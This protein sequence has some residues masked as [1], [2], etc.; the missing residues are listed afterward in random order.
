MNTLLVTV[1]A[2]RAD[3]VGC[4]G[5]SRDTTPALDAFAASNT[6]F[7]NAFANGTFTSAALPAILTGSLRKESTDPL[8]IDKNLLVREP[9]LASV[10]RD[11]GV[12]TRGINTNLLFSVWYERIE[13]FDDFKQFLPAESDGGGEA[14]D[15][16]E[17]DGDRPI[18]KRVGTPV[19]EALG[20][21]RRARQ[22]YDRFQ[23]AEQL[24]STTYYDAAA[25]TD[26]VLKWIDDHDEKSFFIWAHYMDPHEPYGYFDSVR[27][28]PFLNRPIEEFDPSH[29]EEIAKRARQDPDS[30]SERE[31]Q[32][33]I[34][35]YDGYIRF[36]DEHVGRLFDE[37]RQRGVYEETQVIVTADH[38]EE[39][40]EHGMYY[41]HNKPYDE[42]I[43]VPLLVKSPVVESGIRSDQVRH[44]DIAPTVAASHG[45]NT[46]VFDG[47]SLGTDTGDRLVVALGT[48][49]PYVDIS[50]R[51]F[52]ALR[53]PAWKV[54]H[55]DDEPIE[56]YNLEKDSGERTN[57]ASEYPERTA[58]LHEELVGYLEWSGDD[59]EASRSAAL[60]D[61]GE[62]V[63]EHLSDLGY[64]E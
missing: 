45:L 21:K 54:I 29:V 19:A 2:L 33:L 13:G 30:I 26:Q 48:D 18:I 4:H 1:D 8:E 42:L 44:I 23:S 25:V 51:P 53:Y 37:L 50:S 20:V 17:D 31:R 28:S 56:L 9:N 40:G 7:A 6:R 55:H 3:H 41:H 58:E 32:S 61:E 46:E 62:V 14:D 49:R 63:R 15:S 60:E 36:F 39:F 27:A 11:G 59:A 38:G 64:L 35:L 57:V 52:A 24:R 12:R 22:L 43:H 10:L 16:D 5:Y 34:D 47:Q